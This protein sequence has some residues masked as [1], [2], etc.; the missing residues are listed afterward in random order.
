MFVYFRVVLGFM[1]VLWVVYVHLGVFC[2][3][4]EH[5]LVVEALK[6][7]FWRKLVDKCMV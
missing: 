6:C 1:Y 5:V 4:G 2:S 3:D 7:D